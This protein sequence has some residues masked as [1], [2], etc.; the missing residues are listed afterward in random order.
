MKKLK[1]TRENFL[2]NVKTVHKTKN[3]ND[4]KIT[5]FGGRKKNAGVV[6]KT[7]RLRLLK[8]RPV[9]F[10]SVLTALKKQSLELLF[11]LPQNK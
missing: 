9:H 4:M 2:R 7:L 8:K 1:K 10:Y 3:N 6:D 5:G 11:L